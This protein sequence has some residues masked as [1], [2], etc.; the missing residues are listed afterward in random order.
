MGAHLLSWQCLSIIKVNSFN[1]CWD[2]QRI[3][4]RFE[5]EKK[6]FPSRVK[7]DIVHTKRAALIHVLGNRCNKLRF[8]DLCRYKGGIRSGFSPLHRIFF[9]SVGMDWNLKDHEDPG[10][11]YALQPSANIKAFSIW[12]QFNYL[13]GNLGHMQKAEKCFQWS[14]LSANVILLKLW[15]SLWKEKNVGI[16]PNYVVYFDQ[17]CLLTCYSTADCVDFIC[18]LTK[19]FLIEIWKIRFFE[20]ESNIFWIGSDKLIWRKIRKIYGI[21]IPFQP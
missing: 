21:F 9:W 3:I 13:N 15:C 17:F 5:N 20:R 16:S 4:K 12:P 14:E 2:I 10:W 6:I 11:L 18:W 1:Y 8:S 7:S 19:Q